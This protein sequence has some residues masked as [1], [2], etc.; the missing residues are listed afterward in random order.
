MFRHRTSAAKL[1]VAL[2]CVQM[3]Q[4][5]SLT[6]RLRSALVA[7]SWNAYSCGQRS[8]I[9]KN[10]VTKTHPHKSSIAREVWGRVVDVKKPKKGAVA[11]VSCRAE[12]RDA[13]QPPPHGCDTVRARTCPPNLVRRVLTFVLDG[14]TASSS[15]AHKATR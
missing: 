9:A 5:R 15:T 13:S 14:R 7:L 12:R 3:V 8:R 11:T 1:D 4:N 10:L 6:L 2:R